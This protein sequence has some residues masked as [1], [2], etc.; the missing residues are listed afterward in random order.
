[1]GA[2]VICYLGIGLCFAV[3]WEIHWMSR[4]MSPI[5]FIAAWLTWPIVG[6]W[7]LVRWAIKGWP[8]EGR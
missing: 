5:P 1:M 7:V 2:T 8:D 6:L 3:W 4:I